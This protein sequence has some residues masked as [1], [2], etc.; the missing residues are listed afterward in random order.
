[1]A[2]RDL[3]LLAGDMRCLSVSLQAV[4]NE[5]YYIKEMGN[6]DFVLNTLGAIKQLQQ[7]IKIKNIH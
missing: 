5:K 1:M 4:E 2:Y 3:E 6:A 7:S